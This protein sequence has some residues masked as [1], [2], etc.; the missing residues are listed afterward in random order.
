[1]YEFRI[2]FQWSLFLRVQLTIFLHCRIGAKPSSEPKMTQFKDTYICVTRSQ[3]VN[4]LRPRQNGRH[5]PNDSFKWIFFNEN[6]LISIT[7]SLKFVPKGPINKVP[8]LIQIMAW[9]RPGDKPLSEPMMVRLQ[10]HICVTRSQ[11][12]KALALPAFIAVYR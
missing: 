9:C 7:I 8:V 1:M 3:R 12:V 10:T 2:R 4:S 6:V 5:F 11:R